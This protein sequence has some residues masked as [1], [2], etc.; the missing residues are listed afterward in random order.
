MGH[1]FCQIGL[2]Q[3]SSHFYDKNHWKHKKKMQ[4]SR[5]LCIILGKKY[6]TIV[7]FDLNQE[8]WN[9][10]DL[11]IDIQFI[12]LILHVLIDIHCYYDY[13]S[14]I[15]ITMENAVLVLHLWYR[16]FFI[17]MINIYCFC[18]CFLFVEIFLFSF[19]GDLICFFKCKLYFNP[20]LKKFFPW[21]MQIFRVIPTWL[22]IAIAFRKIDFRV[23]VYWNVCSF[24]WIKFLKSLLYIQCSNNS[25]NRLN[26]S[27]S[28]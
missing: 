16:P 4:L 13:N 17:I 15:M 9:I 8:K 26:C 22:T 27:K 5:F 25:L 7:K 3:I 28:F 6:L 23:F 11:T 1:L 24:T 18:C 19:F 10:T 21:R 12:V 14:I 2:K 20:K